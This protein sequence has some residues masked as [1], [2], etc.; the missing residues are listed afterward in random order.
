MCL[1]QTDFPVP[2]GPRIIE[3]LSS[4]M[5]MLSPRRIWLRP[6]AL[7]TSTNSTASV[8]PVGRCLPVCHLIFVVVRAR[9]LTFSLR[10]G[11][12][13]RAPEELGAEHADQVHQHDVEDHRFRRR[14]ADADR[15]A[16]RGVPVVAAD[17]HDHRRHRHRLDHAVQEV[18]WVLEHPEDQRV[19]AAGDL[20]DLLDHR[21]VATRRSRRRSR[22]VHEREHQPGGEQARRAQEG[23]RGD[24]HDL[25]RVD[26]VG[27]PH[28]AELGHDAGADLRGHHV[29]ERVGDQLAQ[30]APGGEH[31][32]VGG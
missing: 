19:A 23:H 31:A 30:V 9:S 25:E 32:R 8:V 3:I 5:A 27:D 2:D 16:A 17:E 6:N 18:G 20:A 10:W 7:W 22:Q 15:S 14:R 29:A 24:A 21:Q 26:L 11:L 1:M 13:V 12:G 4:G 28:R